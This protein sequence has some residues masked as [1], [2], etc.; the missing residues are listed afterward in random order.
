MK[1]QHS[2]WQQKDRERYCFQYLERILT[3]FFEV[4]SEHGEF[5]KSAVLDAF[6]SKYDLPIMG[7]P[8]T[9][10]VLED[11]F[12][13]CV[14][15]H[16][17]GVLKAGMSWYKP[18]ANTRYALLSTD[19]S[20]VWK[21][22][23]SLSEFFEQLLV[24]D[25]SKFSDKE[26]A[27]AF[28]KFGAEYPEWNKM[29]LDIKGDFTAAWHHHVQ[30]NEHHPAHYYLYTP[31]SGLHCLEMPDKFMFEMV[32]DWY[33][34]AAAYKNEK[35]STDIW[36]KENIHKY[37]FHKNTLKN[38]IAYLDNNWYKAA[39]A[40]LTWEFNITDHGGYQILKHKSIQ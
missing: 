32:A 4:A 3:P 28:H 20:R 26:E 33:G 5:S 21:N 40:S 31:N 34:A 19:Q 6:F 22:M 12:Q 9:D 37:A 38:L 25:L 27:Y 30:H 14:I 29:G 24:H 36:F 17:I 18:L 23:P 35:G 15:P 2:Y 10:K 8:T 13:M 7:E 16:K 11:Y 1:K 39:E